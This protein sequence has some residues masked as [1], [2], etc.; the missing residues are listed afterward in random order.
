M[1]DEI[2]GRFQSIYILVSRERKSNDVNNYCY[3]NYD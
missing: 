3:Y 2:E 1:K